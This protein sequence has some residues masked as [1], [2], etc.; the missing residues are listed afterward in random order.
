MK[1]PFH[2][3]RNVHGGSQAVGVRSRRRH[4]VPLAVSVCRHAGRIQTCERVNPGS[5]P[6]LRCGGRSTEWQHRVRDPHGDNWMNA[7]VR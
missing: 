5:E 7:H 6:A 2:L 1:D 3:R 4:L